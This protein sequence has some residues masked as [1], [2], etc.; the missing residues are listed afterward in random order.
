MSDAELYA[1]TG[2]SPNTRLPRSV[3]EEEYVVARSRL[4]M[5][6]RLPRD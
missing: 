2:A 3:L 5:S 4:E 1:K 6:N